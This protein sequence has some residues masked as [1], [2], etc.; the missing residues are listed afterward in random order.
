MRRPE[1]SISRAGE[2]KQNVEMPGNSKARKNFSNN[3]QV[4][5]QK[6]IVNFKLFLPRHTFSINFLKKKLNK[7]KEQS[8]EVCLCASE[9]EISTY[10]CTLL[11]SS[12][13]IEI[14]NV[15]LDIDIAFNYF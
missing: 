11:L 1:I 7:E 14:T 12:L 15:T 9:C 4:Y 3:S 2:G 10:C 13:D 8:K 5:V 6:K